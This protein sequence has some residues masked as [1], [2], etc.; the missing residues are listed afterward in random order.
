MVGVPFGDVKRLHR[1]VP[2]CAAECHDAL[3]FDS[4]YCVGHV[5]SSVVVF[6]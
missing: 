4:G 6:F 2:C 1:G 3:S 5:E